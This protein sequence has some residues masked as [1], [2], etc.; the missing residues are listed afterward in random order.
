M[1]WIPYELL[2]TDVYVAVNIVAFSDSPAYYANDTCTLYVD[3]SPEFGDIRPLDEPRTRKLTI[4]GIHLLDCMD[5]NHAFVTELANAGC[6][7]WPQRDHI[8]NIL[9]PRDRNDKLLEFI[10]RRSVGSFE[11]F[12][13]V[14]S[15][16]QQHLAKFLVTDGGETIT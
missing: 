5:P 1:I 8:I 15:K 12:I 3:I 6:I 10:T 13:K 16:Y 14:L 4:N 11:S 7:T 9:Q 2:Y